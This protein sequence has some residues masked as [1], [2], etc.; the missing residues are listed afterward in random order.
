[1][2][3]TRLRLTQATFYERPVKL[4]L[5]FRFGVVTLTEAPQAFVRARVRLAD[6]REGEG[7]SAEL[8]VPK[9]F[10]KAPTLT[11]EENFDQLRRSLDI[12]RS[13]FLAA[14]TDTPFG[15]SAA[16][17]AAHHAAC[18]RAG[19]NGLVA[20][21]G[22]ALIERAIIDALG[23]L[24]GASV[25]ELV[26][27]NR[28]ALTAAT[29]PDLADFDFDAFLADLRPAASIF[30]RHT[31]GLVDALTRADTAGKRLDDGLPES[32]EEVTATY[33]QRYFKLKVAGSL[34]ADIDRL[35]RIAAVLDRIP[36]PY[37]T[38]LDGNEQFEHVDAV[39]AL[40]HRINAEERLARLKAS[41]LFIEQPIARAKALAEPIHKLTREVA[42][43]IDESDADI[44]VF[45]EARALGYRGIS[46][47]SC[48]GFYRAL[49]N[50]ARIAHWNTQGG[51]P[52]YFMSCED[53]TTQG[54]IAVQQDLA[55]ATLVG[56]THVERNGHHY[57][58]GMAGASEREQLQFLTAH[59]ELYQRTDGRVRLAIR[60]GVLALGSLAHT[61]G[62]AVGVIPEWDA[63]QP[64]RL[65][66]R[67]GA[68]TAIR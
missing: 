29:A 65:S 47:K 22:L 4:R 39:I 67:A 43:E 54:G 38:T 19:L 10:D 57:V 42:V 33:G 26:R 46:V 37:F 3:E 36:E 6:G 25:F 68:E 53:L 63:M 66:D 21:F 45:P 16:V 40:W 51:S 44:G 49:L 48:K 58:D 20:S 60:S 35:A 27:S 7:I 13:H 17:D 52:S 1:M 9:W 11:N 18:E 24:E 55:L 5:P 32:L 30:A 2:S 15:L 8:L 12:A 41:I 34:D 62:L 64:M 50:R 61:A 23:R 31:V 59:P 28:V 14:G 56:A